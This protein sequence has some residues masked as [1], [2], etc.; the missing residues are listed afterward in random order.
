MDGVLLVV[1]ADDGIMP[2]TREHLDILTLL[3]IRHG[4]IALTKVDRVGPERIEQMRADLRAF[5]RGTFLEDA[6]VAPISNVT[7]EGFDGFYEALDGLIN[8]IRPKG[9]EGV[10]R[11]PAERAFSVQ[12]YGTVVTGIPVSGSARLN[13]EVV[14]LPQGTTGRIN[15]IQVYGRESDV[16]LAGQCAA[17]NVRHWEHREIGRGNVVTV[18]GFFAPEMWYAVKLRLLVKAG[19]FLKN[20][21]RV[22][23]HTG[24]SEVPATVYLLEGEQMSAGDERGV[25][26]RLDAPIVAGPA[27]R[28]ILRTLSP[29]ETIGGGFIIE[30]IREKLKRSRPEVRVELEARAKAVLNER[31]FVEYSVRRAPG[32]AAT[33]AEVSVRAKSPRSRVSAILKELAAEGKISPLTSTLFVHRDTAAEVAERIAAVVGEYHG[34]SPESPGMTREQLQEKSRIAKNV[35]DGFVARMLADGALVERNRR[36]ALPTHREEFSEEERKVVEQVE[37]LFRTRAYSPPSPDD[38]VGLTRLAKPKVDKAL[39]ILIEHGKLI[40]VQ[41]DILFHAEAIARAKQALVDFITKEGKLESVKFK[42]LV[43][44]SRKYALPLLDYFDRIG[45]LLRV[46]N[47]RYLKTPKGPAGT[48]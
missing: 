43:D 6:T 34:A 40:H 15:A 28:F 7:G 14:L 11:L 23:F 2:Q 38:V 46:G 24:T 1:A 18:P 8:S 26:V 17:V 9:V 41:E 27:D 22:K 48:K 13:D 4:M 16:V 37:S 35:L 36:L 25:Q 29:P 21:M 3:G 32:F 44:T 42:Y 47:T 31:D 12:G 33:E 20:A 30:A 39:K 19:F 10:F 45:V 5:L